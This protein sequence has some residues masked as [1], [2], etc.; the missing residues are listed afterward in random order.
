VTPDQVETESLAFAEDG[1]DALLAHAAGCPAC[2]VLAARYQLLR[3]SLRVWHRPPR[4]PAD[5][6]QRILRAAIEDHEKARW[7]WR[8]RWATGRARRLWRAGQ[9]VTTTLA[10][11]SLAIAAALPLCILML[12]RLQP[13]RLTNPPANPASDPRHNLHAVSGSRPELVDPR[14]L[15]RALLDATS[16]TWDL[17][18]TASEPAA[19]ISWDAFDAVTQAEV[20]VGEHFEAGPS[21]G[22]A[23]ISAAV[24]SLIPPMPDPSAASAVLQ[25]VGDQLAEG[26]RPLSHTARRAFGF[27]LGPARGQ[28]VPRTS[29]PP[30]RGA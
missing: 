29:P 28:R 13:G 27:L 26:V 10:V 3:R 7:L 15:N 19:R 12:D 14:A 4:L 11:A 5:L 16:A 21:P 1:E 20:S 24:P 9:P 6:A 30:A 22:S 2:R 17:A 23:G 8:A 18:R 25:Q